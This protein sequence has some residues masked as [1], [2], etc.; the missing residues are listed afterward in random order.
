MHKAIAKAV[1]GLTLAA[2]MTFTAVSVHAGTPVT[3]KDGGDAL[4]RLEVPNFWTLRTGGLRTLAGPEE[5]DLRDVSRVFGMSPDAHPG[6]WVGLI[7]P[8]GVSTL[9][10][11]RE[12]LR[13]IGPFLVEDATVSEPMARRIGGMPARRIIGTGRRNGKTLDFTVLAIDLPGDRIAI[14]VVVFEQGADP[15]PVGDINVMLNS[16][17]AVR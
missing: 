1:T 16:I 12:Y 17:R 4:F 5:N 14:A 13:D 11:A 8:H 2:V 6:I 3:Y 10:Q 7:S 9:S 15:E